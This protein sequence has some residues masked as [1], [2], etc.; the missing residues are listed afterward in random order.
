VID[1]DRASGL[2]QHV[3]LRGR[4][5]VEPFERERARRLLASYLGDDEARWD[6][7]FR[8]TLSDSDNVLIR[9]VPESAVVRD[10]SY[11]AGG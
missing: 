11:E 6:E 4:S 9:F 2:V 8:E 10:V 1:F 3:G 7:R 5:T